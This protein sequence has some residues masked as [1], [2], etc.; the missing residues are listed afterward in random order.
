MYWAFALVPVCLAFATLAVAQL[1]R[2]ERRDQAA[3]E[4]IPAPRNG[5]R[6]LLRLRPAAARR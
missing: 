2:L 5:K 6:Y 1:A 3:E 4:A